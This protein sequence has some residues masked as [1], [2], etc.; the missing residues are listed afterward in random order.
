MGWRRDMRTVL[1]N[2]RL[3]TH[4]TDEPPPEPLYPY[5]EPDLTDIRIEYP[6]EPRAQQNIRLREA[7]NLYK[8]RQA[9]DT[10]EIKAGEIMLAS[11]SQ[12]VL[13]R[14]DGHAGSTKQIWEAL[15]REYMGNNFILADTELERLH[16]SQYDEFGSATAYVQHIKT[17]V[18]LLKDMGIVIPDFEHSHILLKGLGDS[19]RD[20]IISL[21]GDTRVGEPEI[22]VDRIISA[23]NNI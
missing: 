15:Q 23:E 18:D 3:W 13:S 17:M 21:R 22:L 11:I 16:A 5:R 6:D 2:Q 1:N 4:V 8:R 7:I 10:A 20:V 14:I 12:P 9:W 19:F